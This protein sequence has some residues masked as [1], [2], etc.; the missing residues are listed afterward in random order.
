[1]SVS[2][3]VPLPQSDAP[4]ERRAPRPARPALLAYVKRLWRQLPI[5]VR[6]RLYGVFNWTGLP[7]FL[8]Y[9]ASYRETH[10]PENFAGNLLSLNEEF[11]NGDAVK[12]KECARLF[13]AIVDALVLPNGV[14]KTTYADRQN[15]VLER[16]LADDCCR[17]D[18]AELRVLD[19]PASS[20][21]ASLGSL[22][23][24]SRQYRISRY[25]LGDLSFEILYDRT[26][27]CVFDDRGNLLQVGTRNGFFSIHRPHRLGVEFS[28]LTRCL[29]LPLE[30][31]AWYLRRRYSFVATNDLVPIGLVHPAVDEL[32]RAGTFRL[33]RVDVFEA[34]E[35]EYDLILSFNLLQ[36]NYF[37]GDQ[38]ARGLRTLTGALSEGGILVVGSPDAGGLSA[39]QVARKSRGELVVVREKTR[40]LPRP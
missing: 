6:R 24:L 9:A 2:A 14:R 1:M 30:V 33:K 27:N 40:V 34:I 23:V 32:V 22:E 3:G 12:R 15:A 8:A 25:V 28:A 19:V 18:R 35:D 13:D 10:S 37:S 16:V 21:I 20:G 11:A 5:E 29:L 4:G 26:R 17:P 39:Y 31:R 36:P 7:L 38:I